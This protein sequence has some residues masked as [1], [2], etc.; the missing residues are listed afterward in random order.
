ML[1]IVTQDTE[2]GRW[3]DFASGKVPSVGVQIPL[4]ADWDVPFNV[5]WWGV[6][7]AQRLKEFTLRLI[8]EDQKIEQRGGAIRSVCYGPDWKEI[9]ETY[10]GNEPKVRSG[11]LSLR[12]EYVPSYPRM[13]EAKGKIITW[14]RFSAYPDPYDE[15][16]TE[17]IGIFVPYHIFTQ[18]ETEVE[19]FIQSTSTRSLQHSDFT[20]IVKRIRSELSRP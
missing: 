8:D 5:F 1:S 9:F 17:S 4:G 13:M 2:N 15:D 10:V 20:E 16:A 18:I 11:T 14:A 12:F 19:S 7:D 6:V 3:L